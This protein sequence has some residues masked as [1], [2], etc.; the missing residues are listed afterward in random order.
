M[1]FKTPYSCRG[2]EYLAIEK[3]KRWNN[4]MYSNMQIQPRQ[5]P[6]MF[7]MN[8]L[9]HHIDTNFNWNDIFYLYAG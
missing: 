2:I 5:Y 6:H 1:Y 3:F 4:Q 7:N 9:A 8:K